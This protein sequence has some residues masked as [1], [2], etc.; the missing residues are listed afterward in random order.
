MFVTARPIFQSKN[1]FKLFKY[2]KRKKNINFDLNFSRDGSS[3]LIMT[4]K[5]LRIRGG[6][7]ILIPAYIGES[8]PKILKFYNYKVLYYQ[9]NL[10]GSINFLKIKDIIK[11]KNAKSI[12]LV[13]YFG[14][15]YSHNLQIAKK[16]KKLNCKIIH[17]CSHTFEL[18]N[19]YNYFNGKI[20]SLR[21]VFPLPS[22]GAYWYENKSKNNYPV[23]LFMSDFIFIFKDLI[24]NFLKYFPILN[25]FLLNFDG[26]QL[27]KNKHKIYD[28]SKINF[29]TYF[30][31][32]SKR[33]L[34]KNLKIRKNNFDYLIKL[35][36]KNKSKLIFN[37]FHKNFIPQ[38]VTILNSN[39]KL[40]NEIRRNGYKIYRWPG[41]ELPKKIKKMKEFGNTR[42]LNK[43]I[44]CIPIHQLVDKTSIKK[45]SKIISTYEK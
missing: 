33:M 39:Q 25:K 21:K 15:N 12:L 27:N 23:K 38:A 36:K 10:D 20:F 6:N 2:Y 40:F 26:N 41:K 11:N 8:V 4:L 24:L 30:F 22:I 5:N 16:I 37:S 17:D 35:L 43:N 19:N 3:A 42:F 34:E 14:L 7:K 44:V 13:N 9:L 31:L 1:L 32:H 45:L 29:L 28:F 18:K